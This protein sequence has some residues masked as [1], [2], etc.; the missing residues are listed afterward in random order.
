MSAVFTSINVISCVESHSPVTLNVHP[1]NINYGRLHR[2][3]T[4]LFV[5]HVVVPG[6]G[7][8]WDTDV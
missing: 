4:P 3:L 2:E 7:V 6:L 1:T 5:E 8:G